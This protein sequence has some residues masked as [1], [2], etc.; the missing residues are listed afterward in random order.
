MSLAIVGGTVVDLIFP[1]V[2]RLPA[3]PRHTESTPANLELLR[4]PPI[5]TLGGNGANAAFVAARCGAAVTLHTQLGDDTLGVLARGWLDAAG[6][7]L[8]LGDR[9]VRT[10]VNV[11][12]ANPS[13]A[14][15]TFF[16]PGAPVVMPKF[17]NGRHASTHLLV[18]GWP[19]PPF[20]ELTTA[21]RA[22]RRRGVFIALD[23]GPILG[24]PWSL[25]KL[26]PA[27][28]ELSLFLVNEFEL[29]QITRAARLGQALKRLRRDFS[30]HVVIKRGAEGA[31]WLPANAEVPRAFAGR[32][33]RVINT[34]GAGDSFNGALLAGLSLGATFPVALGRACTVAASVVNSPRG[35]LGVRP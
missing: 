1:R 4:E 25:A 21:L 27:L 33:V 10:A 34:L 18:C 28:A 32:R 11:T 12:A 23:A 24:R 6:C 17:T 20:A 9:G 7:R 15:A 2:R 26:R 3:W 30:G 35:V 22:L 14:R 31:L 19:H 13:L 5:V 29:R 8:R 16:Y